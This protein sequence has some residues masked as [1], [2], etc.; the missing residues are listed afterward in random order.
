MADADT[1]RIMLSRIEELSTLVDMERRWRLDAEREFD[2][3]KSHQQFVPAA[4]VDDLLSALCGRQMIPAIKAYRA[5]TGAGLK[6]SKDAVE[7]FYDKFYA[8]IESGRAE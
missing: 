1:I 3:L 7:R 2:S 4:M 6:E 8:A 5:L